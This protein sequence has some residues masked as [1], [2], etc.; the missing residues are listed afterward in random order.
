VGPQIA[1]RPHPVHL[2]LRIADQHRVPQFHR[3]RPDS[4]HP[5]ARLCDLRLRPDL[6]R[7]FASGFTALGLRKPYPRESASTINGVLYPVEGDDMSKFDAREEGYA[8][9]EVPRDDI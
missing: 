1:G 3:Q 4:S 8:R 6:E 5:G 9:V 2:R 7:P